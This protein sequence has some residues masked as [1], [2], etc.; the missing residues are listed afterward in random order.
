ML[1]EDNQL[2]KF[3]NSIKEYLKFDDP[4]KKAYN[5]YVSGLTH[6]IYSDTD[7]CKIYAKC[8][9][10]KQRALNLLLQSYTVILIYCILFRM[11]LTTHTVYSIWQGHMQ[12]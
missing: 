9:L 4:K 7:D 2:L 6:S 11:T 1:A 10:M 3:D 5:Y 8:K 12:K